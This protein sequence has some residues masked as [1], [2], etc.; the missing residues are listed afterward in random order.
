LSVCD[1]GVHETTAEQFPGSL[2]ITIFEGQLEITGAS[3][4]VIVTIKLQVSVFPEASVAVYTTVV[5]PAENVSPGL[6]VDE[7]VALQLSVCKGGVQVTTAVH[8]PGSAFCVILKGQLEITGS[9]VSSTVTVKE[10]VSEL[11]AA[12]VAE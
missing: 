2:V 11:P 9:L 4:S 1:G 3:F 8:T 6:W 12:S 5:S 10:Q 7:S